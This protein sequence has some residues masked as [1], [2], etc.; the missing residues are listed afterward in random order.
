MTRIAHISDVHFGR[1]A[2]TG[3][4]DAL[5]EDIHAQ[6]PDMVA[7]S[8]D[9]TQRAY[10]WQYRK[11]S[12]FVRSFRMPVLVVPGNHDVW[13]MW[14]PGRRLRRPVSR[15]ETVITDDLSPLVKLPDAWILGVNSAH[16][17]TVKGGKIRRRDIEALPAAFKG[18]P[19]I[20]LIVVHH[21]LTAIP[22]AGKADI[23]RRG[24]ELLRVAAENRVQVVLSGHIHVAQNVR[25]EQGPIIVTAGTATSTRGRGP[26]RDAN[27]Y[28]MVELDEE[29]VAVERRDYDG[30]EFSVTSRETLAVSPEILRPGIGIGA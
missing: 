5:V 18:G 10:S 13:P 1:I 21:P 28:N 11:A 20:R 12:A 27:T 4:V 15:Y 25:T 3:V 29:S 7:I 6:K 22:H 14:W 26:D 17:R 30:T 2:R 8:G 23:A 19:D 9:L 16:G 24:D